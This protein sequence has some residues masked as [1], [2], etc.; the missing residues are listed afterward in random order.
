MESAKERKMKRIWRIL[1]LGLALGASAAQAAPRAALFVQNQA[2]APLES[3]LDAFAELAG[4]RLSAAGFEVIR[5][6]DV[7]ARFAESRDAQSEQVLRRAVEALQTAKSEG[8]ADEPMQAASALRL[9]QLMGADYLVFASL[10]SLGENQ[11]QFQGYGIAQGTSTRTLRVALRVLEGGTGA[12]LY[13]DT[14]P[15]SDTLAQNANLQVEAGD[16]VNALLDRGAGELAGRVSGSLAKIEAAKPA[17]AAL[18]NVNVTATAEGATVEVDGVAV[19]SA[20]GAFQLRPGVHRMRVAKEGY[21]TWEK[22]VNVFDGQTLNVALEL[23]AEGL[24]RK[25]EL[26]AQARTDAI[27]REQSAADAQATTTLAGGQARQASN[28]YIRLEGMPDSLTVGDTEGKDAN[29]INVIQQ[30]G[31]Q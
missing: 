31:Q 23:S 22:S 2:G 9:A 4:A 24:A 5:P 10:V 7:L 19:G 1:G 30:E 6:Q 8:T 17:A 25:S 21:A 13:G 20:P 26:E 3:K 11:A 28:S 15:V 18:A 12:Q 14:I 27:A 16:Q 29:L